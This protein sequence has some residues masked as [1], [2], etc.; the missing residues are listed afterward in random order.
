MA[1]VFDCAPASL[2]TGCAGDG[3]VVLPIVGYAE[4]RDSLRHMIHAY[5]PLSA[6]LGMLAAAVAW[7]HAGSAGRAAKGGPDA[8]D[9]D[10]FGRDYRVARLPLPPKPQGPG[11]GARGRTGGRVPR[12]PRRARP[13]PGRGHLL[14]RPLRRPADP[15]RHRHRA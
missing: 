8:R 2:V 15:G 1:V 10:R 7:T 5:G 11:A 6:A 3:E 9:E 12:C 4:W 13:L 14:P